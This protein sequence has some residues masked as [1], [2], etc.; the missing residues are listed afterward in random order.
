MNPS[1]QLLF[2]L[3]AKHKSYHDDVFKLNYTLCSVGSGLLPV[4]IYANDIELVDII[5]GN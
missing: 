5:F 4:S 3:S 2:P 1:G